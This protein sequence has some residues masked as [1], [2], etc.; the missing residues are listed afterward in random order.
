VDLHHPG[1]RISE[2]C[3]DLFEAERAVGLERQ[4]VVATLGTDGLGDGGLGADGVDRDQGAG[5]FQTFEQQRDRGDLVRFVVLA[6]T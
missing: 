6:R 3:R 4:Q 1:W 2:E 5:Q